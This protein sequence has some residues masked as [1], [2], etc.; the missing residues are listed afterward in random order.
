MASSVRKMAVYLGLM[1]DQ[2]PAAAPAAASRPLRTVESLPGVSTP[3]EAPSIS[4][5]VSRITTLHPRSYN[6]AKPVGEDFRQGIPVIMNL[7]E[8]NDIDA[9]RIVDFA[10][11]LTFGLNG[12]I[13]RITS[14][15]FLLS[16]ANVDLGASARAQLLE[17][18]FYNQS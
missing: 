5:G 12:R 9:R 7:T 6:D 11:G 2:E 15:V 13:E 3:T 1:E 8:L 18:G 4:D 14:K 17:D 10:A 16:P